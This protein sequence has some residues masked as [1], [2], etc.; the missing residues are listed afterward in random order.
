MGAANAWPNTFL[1]A[2]NYHNHLSAR[3]LLFCLISLLGAS[4]FREFG[5]VDQSVSFFSF[6]LSVWQMDCKQKKMHICDLQKKK[7]AYMWEFNPCQ[8]TL[9]FCIY[10]SCMP[11]GARSTKKSGNMIQNSAIRK[12]GRHGT[13]AHQFVSVYVVS[14]EQRI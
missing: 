13:R 1:F 5:S 9:I 14:A 8:T 6:S 10:G 7:D 11:W 12:I 2:P 3:V 4:C